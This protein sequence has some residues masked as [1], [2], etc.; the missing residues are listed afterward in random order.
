[1]HTTSGPP[2]AATP[3][4]G[5]IARELE[6]HSRRAT[7]LPAGDIV[8]LDSGD[9]DFATPD[10]I[11]RALHDAVEAGM[12]HYGEPF[13]DVELRT[14]LAE[15]INARRGAGRCGVEQVIVTHGASGGLG[16][17]ILACVDPG[18][19]VVIPEPTYSLYADQVRAAGAQPVFVRTRADFHLDLDAIEVAARGARMLVLCHPCN[20]TGAVLRRDELEEVSHI[21]A[22]HDLLVL[23]DEAYDAIVHDGIAFTSTLDVDALADRLI[24]CQTFSKRYAMTGWRV[25]YVVAPRALA[26]AI[27]RVHFT[28][29]GPPNTAVQRAALAAV[30]GGDECVAPML[31]EYARRRDMVLAHLG[32]VRGVRIAPAEGTFYVFFAY[33]QQVDSVAMQQRLLDHGVALRAGSEFGDGGEGY[34]RLSYTASPKVLEQGLARLR[35]A[36]TQP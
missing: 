15:Q 32:D 17:A 19:R 24:Y 11:R 8:L 7:A 25:G 14:A 30:R 12:T 3:R 2:S 23:S 4:L 31:R 28:L 1:M 16:A 26:A 20:P 35:A 27:G 36:L 13:G 34:L 10:H 22:A 9:P 6:E 33:P 29:H 5:R 18:D 21:A